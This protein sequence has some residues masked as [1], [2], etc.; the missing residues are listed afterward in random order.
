M[1]DVVVNLGS[2]RAEVEAHDKEWDAVTESIDFHASLCRYFYTTGA[3]V[4]LAHE[5]SES[6]R[7]WSDVDDERKDNMA[8]LVALSVS[9]GL[10]AVY[11]VGLRGVMIFFRRSVP[12]GNFIYAQKGRQ[13]RGARRGWDFHRR[14]HMVLF[15]RE[16]CYTLRHLDDALRKLEA[17]GY[18][19]TGRKGTRRL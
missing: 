6:L 14:T 11:D 17:S 10:G 4:D 7:R 19:S 13:R 3:A 8:G 9:A 2:R 15:S 12:S 1:T 18:P 5:R 16:R